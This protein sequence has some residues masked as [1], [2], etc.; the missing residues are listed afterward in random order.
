L[1]AFSG[2]AQESITRGLGW[3]FM[4][5]GR[6]I[7]RA[8]NLTNLLRVGLAQSA[9]DRRS[10]LEAILEVAAS[11]M[12]YRSRY[13]KTF[14]LPQVLDLL[15]LD[16]TNPKSLAF[17]CSQLS[18]H[19]E[20]LP[21][22]TD[23]RFASPEERLALEMLTSVRLLDLTRLG[24]MKSDAQNQTLMTFLESMAGRLKDFSQEI[25]AQYLSR[26]P[27]TPHFSVISG[28]TRR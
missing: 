13:R 12:T 24:V 26:V 9:R 18:S 4:D 1:S 28:D 17:Q 21:R 25:S 14:Q 10:D 7:E 23:R 11:I 19:V 3:R 27:T 22:Q 16:E 8:L 6:R 20:S 15:L 2:L 5:M